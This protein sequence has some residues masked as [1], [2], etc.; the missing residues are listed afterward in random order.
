MFAAELGH[1]SGRGAAEELHP[2]G[3]VPAHDRRPARP[4]TRATTRA[5]STSRSA[6]PATTSCAPSSSA[7][8][9][10]ATTKQLGIGI[11]SLRRDHEPARRG[12]V[13]RGRDH[14]G[15]R[16]D[17][18]HRL[19]LARPGPR[20]DVRDDRRRAARAARSRRSPSHKGDTD[21]IAEGHR[22]VRLE[23]DADRRHGRSGAP[24]TTSSSRRRSSSA[25]YLEA[26]VDDIVLDRGLGR[27]HVVGH[28]ASR[29]SRGRSSPRAR[30][31]TDG[32]AS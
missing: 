7:A 31:R 17:R 6:R 15:R 19:V 24:P 21:E 25:D 9:T 13:R 4:T 10:R 5:R 8:A 32:S 1:G 3:R 26:S 2:E 30:R 20:D 29:R 12:R 18:P 14:A 23:V 27:F 22:H 16:R 28:A 11:S